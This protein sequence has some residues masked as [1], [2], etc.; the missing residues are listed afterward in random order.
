MTKSSQ[1]TISIL[2]NNWNVSYAANRFPQGK[3]LIHVGVQRCRYLESD[4]Q[5]R[6][7]LVGFDGVYGFAADPCAV[8]KFT[9]GQ[10]GSV[11]IRPEPDLQPRPM[12][13]GQGAHPVIVVSG[14]VR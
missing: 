4:Y 6:P 3:N 14:R 1:T 7:L 5:S 11:P 10:M 13:L 12:M 9:L 2:N 8:G